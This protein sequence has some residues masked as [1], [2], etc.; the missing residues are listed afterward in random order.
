MATFF[1]G[2][3][4]LEIKKVSGSG[5]TNATV[6]TVPANRY[7]KVF[8]QR[9]VRNSPGIPQSYSLS[10]GGTVKNDGDG[11]FAVD[12]ANLFGN[13]FILNSGDTIQYATGSPVFYNFAIREFA[14][15]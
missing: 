14:N 10:I 11:N 7:A 8:V 9:Y 12:F 1:G 2:E 6:Y 15:P 5:N 13:S 3:T 4:L